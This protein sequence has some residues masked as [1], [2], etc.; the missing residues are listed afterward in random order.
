MEGISPVVAE[1]AAA[2]K[3]AAEAYL[4]S[5]TFENPSLFN[6][7]SETGVAAPRTEL[8][9]V[10][11]KNYPAVGQNLGALI[12]VHQ[13]GNETETQPESLEDE[14]PQEPPKKSRWGPQLLDDP[15]AKRGRTLALQ[16]RLRKS[17][18]PTH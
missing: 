13:S 14:I 2:A 16:V 5:Q 6:L 12:P 1:A 18:S 11:P 4:S 7:N 17:F 3:R 15:L 10:I 8:G 9:F